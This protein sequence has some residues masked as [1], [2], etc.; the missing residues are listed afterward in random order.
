MLSAVYHKKALVLKSPLVPPF[1]KGGML[2]FILCPKGDNKDYGSWLTPHPSVLVTR[3]VLT[4]T[5]EPVLQTCGRTSRQAG[6]ALRGSRFQR[7]NPL[8]GRKFGRPF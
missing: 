2:V 3:L 4:D 1:P 7:Y 8:P 6:R 5:I